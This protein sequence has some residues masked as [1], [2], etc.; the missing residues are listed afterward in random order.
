MIEVADGAT[1][2]VNDV[3]HVSMLLFMNYAD[4]ATTM[5]ES[6]GGGG[7]VESNWGRRKDDDDEEWTCRC[8]RKANWL[9]KPM[10][11]S[12]RR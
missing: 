6:L 9:C 1:Q 7:G 2:T 10:R 8:A 11:R 12:Y 3:L 4:A 5:A